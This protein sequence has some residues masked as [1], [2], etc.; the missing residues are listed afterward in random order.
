M[1]L[2]HKIGKLTSG[3]TYARA[4]RKIRRGLHPVRLK[5]L[6][7]Q[8][9][10]NR[11]REIQQRYAASPLNYAKYAKVEFW[12]KRHIQRVQ[13]LGLHR[14]PPQEILDLG[15]GGGFFLFVA[16]QFGHSG[17]GIDTGE[18]PLLVELMALFDVPLQVWPIQP[19]Q[20]LPDLG[21]KFDW[22]TAF[23]TRFNRDR[24]DR[25]VWGVKE[26]NFFLDDL[27][28]HLKPAGQVFLEINSGK[29]KQYFP[30]EVRQLFLKRG[31]SVERENI[32]F[33]QGP[34]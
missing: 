28:G 26:W 18:F 29:S 31:A 27:R 3:E 13:D 8:I 7:E 22:I 10:Q 23:S 5:P 6:L 16:K 19:F 2:A 32:H 33:P 9:D 1:K 14:S 11:L 21:R 4:R 20:P 17:I 12:L 34:L 30:E 24:E 25:M 15:C